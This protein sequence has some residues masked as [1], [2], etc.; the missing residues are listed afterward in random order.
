MNEQANPRDGLR[1]RRAKLERDEVAA[2][3]LLCD[4]GLAALV[5]LEEIRDQEV[6][7]AANQSA[8]AQALQTAIDGLNAELANT[9]AL[10]KELIADLVVIPE[11]LER[12][13]PSTVEQVNAVAAVT[14]QLQSLSAKLKAAAAPAEAAEQAAQAPAPTPGPVAGGGGQPEAPKLTKT[15]YTFDASSGAA[16]DGRFTASG[17]ETVP[18]EGGAAVPIEY[19]ADDTADGDKKGAEVPGYVV[20]DGPVQ[21]VATA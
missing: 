2:L 18:A 17:F 6:V 7:M 5:L 3:H 10:D 19:F 14:T 4:I 13:Q 11:L 20:Y 9:E 16:A 1:E 21:A 12:I 8:E 15:G